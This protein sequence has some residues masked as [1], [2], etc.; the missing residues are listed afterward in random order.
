MF[1]VKDSKY[2]RY[3]IFLEAYTPKKQKGPFHSIQ[4]F[5]G[6]SLPPCAN[7]L[8]EKTK[9]TNQICAIWRHSTKNA[10]NFYDPQ[11]HGW[12][13]NDNQYV[14]NWFS[15]LQQPVNLDDI[16]VNQE[17]NDEEDDNCDYDSSDDDE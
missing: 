1:G 10:P 11:N 6:S 14:I 4:K 16:I 3:A 9:R 13:L 5:D 12:V 8:L 17:S 7:V 2:F 15:G